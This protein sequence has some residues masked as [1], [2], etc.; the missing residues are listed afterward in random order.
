MATP[1]FYIQFL[2]SLHL[3]SETFYFTLLELNISLTL[4]EVIRSLKKTYYFA[5][6][7]FSYG[8]LEKFAQQHPA[9]RVSSRMPLCWQ[10]CQR[11]QPAGQVKGCVVAEGW[12]RRKALGSKEWAFPSPHSSHYSKS[13]PFFLLLLLYPWPPLE[14]TDLENIWWVQATKSGTGPSVACK[15]Q[16]YWANYKIIIWW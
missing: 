8:I 4:R 11:L 10:P 13:P 12:Q 15:Q 5:I 3:K 9:S 16:K 2:I 7:C 1:I 14:F 6:H